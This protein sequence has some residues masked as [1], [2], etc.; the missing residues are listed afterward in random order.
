MTESNYDKWLKSVQPKTRA[1]YKTAWSVLAEFY[2]DTKSVTMTPDKFLSALIKDRKKP[3]EKQ[4]QL[5]HDLVEWV[6]WLQNGYGK[7]NRGLKGGKTGVKGVSAGSIK[8]YMTGVRSFLSYYGYPL[9]KKA[10]LPRHIRLSNGK[11]ENIKIEYRPEQMKKLLSVIKSHRDKTIALFM[12]QSAMDISTVCSLNYGDVEE[13][14]SRGDE[15][16]M[17]HVKRPKIG[18]NYRTFIGRDSIETLR[19]YLNERV[20]KYGEKMSYETPLFMT[21]GTYVNRRKRC[22]PKN[23]QDNMRNYVLLAGLISKDKL[24]R[25]DL[26]PARPH[27]LRSGFATIARLKGLNEKLIDYFMGHSDPYGGAYNQA[28]NKELRDKYMEIEEALSVSSVSNLSDIEGKLREE[29][30][31]RDYVIQGMR[32]EINELKEEFR[33]LKDLLPLLKKA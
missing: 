17:I 25:A 23:F 31:E 19:T 15:P 30:K 26:S 6:T 10:Q 8:I 7:R 27:A 14:L 5:E 3:I 2:Q 1:N 11:L 4:G 13:G 22:K 24:E 28:T 20:N 16:L 18:L 32:E 29:L 21:E 12:F 9:S 33:V